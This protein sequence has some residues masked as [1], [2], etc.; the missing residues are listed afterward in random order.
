M[1]EKHCFAYRNGRCKVLTV[2]KCEGEQCSFLKTPA[3]V[4]EDKK[5]VFR[6][7]KSLDE[8]SRRH[9]MDL[10]FGGKMS[11]LDELEVD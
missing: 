3:Q 4:E 11:L 8:A 10:Y 1:M 7:I 2:K 6:R 5:H 9:I